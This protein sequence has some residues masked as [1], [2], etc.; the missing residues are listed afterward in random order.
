MVYV[1]AQHL[2]AQMDLECHVP[3]IG[4]W[5]V[6]HSRACGRRSSV[7]T[8]CSCFLRQKQKRWCYSLHDII[9]IQSTSKPTEARSLQFYPR[10]KI[11]AA[12]LTFHQQY[13]NRLENVARI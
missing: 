6:V 7:V 11:G 10:A 8:A 9:A 5:T 4:H 3:L 1:L 12:L 2:R 13:L